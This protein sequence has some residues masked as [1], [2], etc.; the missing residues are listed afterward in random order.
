MCATGADSNQFAVLDS[1]FRVRGKKG[2]RLDRSA[3]P[4]PPGALPVLPTFMLSSKA[5]DAIFR[6]L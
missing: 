3:F 5:V 2:L 4:K 1:N 6:G